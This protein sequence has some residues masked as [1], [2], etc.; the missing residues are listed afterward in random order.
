MPKLRAV[1]TPFKAD[2]T[3]CEPHRA[4]RAP[5]VLPATAALL[6]NGP[7]MVVLNKTDLVSQA[8]VEAWL[9]Y[10][11]AAFPAVAAFVPFSASASV[12]P[13]SATGISARRRAIKDARACFDGDH[14]ARRAGCVRRLLE[15]A[16]AHSDDIAAVVTK[17]EATKRTRSSG[18]GGGSMARDERVDA[19]AELAAAMRQQK[20]AKARRKGRGR[21]RRHSA[22]GGSERYDDSD[23][24]ADAG[25]ASSLEEHN[26][27]DSSGSGRDE[28]EDEGSDEEAGGTG[29]ADD[30]NDG[31]DDDSEGSDCEDDAAPKPS[32]LAAAAGRKGVSFAAL[33][34]DSSS[35]GD[36]GNDGDG[37]EEEAAAAVTVNNRG[38]KAVGAGRALLKEEDDAEDS[39][40]PVIS[41]KMIR[42]RERKAKK[43]QKAAQPPQKQPAQQKQPAG[44]MPEPSSSSASS[45]FPTSAAALTIGMI[46]HPNVGKSSVINTLAGEKRVSVSR[47]AG[48][49]KR[50]QTIPLVPGRLHLL[51]CPGLV[52][53]HALVPPPEGVSLPPAFPTRQAAAAAFGDPDEE[54]GMQELCGVIPLAQ[55]REPYSAVRVLAERLPLERL[56]GLT[57]PKDDEE[58][59]WSPLLL[60][61]QLAVKRGYHIA[62]TGR[63]DGHAAGREILYD[64]QDGNVPVAW[65]PPG[66]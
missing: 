60:C 45:S 41:E 39:D 34:L 32:K 1:C 23:S 3:V 31:S 2:R 8:H 26:S 33:A 56:Y 36:D 53:P 15:A 38:S 43:A 66:S 20:L 47:T 14:V 54:R 55:V 25:S 6:S 28:Q 27:N 10:L 58:E 19:A 57:L 64:T 42:R 62:R 52:F 48:H 51:D 50:A 9:A 35:E 16:G 29:S 37:A 44:A 65:L 49:T 12:L 17:I 30:S 24:D 59:A 21:G 40:G 22:D 11:K 61:E 18:T 63:P 46:G 4:G 5:V 13:P 7:L